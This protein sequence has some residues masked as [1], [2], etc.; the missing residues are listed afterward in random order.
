MKHAF[1]MYSFSDGHIRH[2][3]LNSE[4]CIQSCGGK[5]LKKSDQCPG[6]DMI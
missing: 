1:R 4:K 5:S 3:A 6:N 2:I